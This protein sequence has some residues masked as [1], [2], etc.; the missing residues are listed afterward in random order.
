[1]N[2]KWEDVKADYA[3]YETEI[4]DL[5]DTIGELEAEIKE[6]KSNGESTADMEAWNGLL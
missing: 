2:V 5:K 1:M 6:L 4:V 3:R